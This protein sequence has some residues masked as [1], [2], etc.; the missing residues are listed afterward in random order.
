MEC[1]EDYVLEQNYPN[2]FNQVTTVSFTIPKAARVRLFVI[3]AMGHL[4][5][6]RQQLCEAGRNTIHVDVSDGRLSS[7]IYFYGIECDDHRLMRK[8]IVR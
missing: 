4:C 2:P 5:Y 1:D 6:Q 3:D 7:G 8:M